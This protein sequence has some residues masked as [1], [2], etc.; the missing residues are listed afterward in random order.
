MKFVFHT[1]VKANGSSSEPFQ[2]LGD[3]TVEHINWSRGHL[4]EVDIY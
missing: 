3:Y 1:M 4:E 2:V